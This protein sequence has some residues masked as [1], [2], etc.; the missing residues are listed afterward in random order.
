[1][2]W[3][4][5]KYHELLRDARPVL[6]SE[7]RE[8][9][10]VYP[11]SV[12]KT[13]SIT[14]DQLSPLA[15]ALLRIAAWFAPDAIPCGI[16]SADQGVLSEM[17]A[18]KVTV[19]D[20]AI[21]KALGELDNFSLIRLIGETGSMHPLLQAVEQDSLTGEERQRWLQ[22]SVRL[23]NAVMPNSPSDDVWLPLWPHAETLLEH[24]KRLS[25]DALPIALMA[26]EF[27]VFLDARLVHASRT[28]VSPRT[29]NL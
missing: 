18:E 13:W 19:S 24:T 3:S 11:T 7:H 26:N 15:R 21:E 29:C 20:L 28:V 1:M 14:L 22:C 8:G 4:F 10:T 27:A 23:F 5:D 9:G 12:A 16:F 2:R 6:L 17:L 25:L